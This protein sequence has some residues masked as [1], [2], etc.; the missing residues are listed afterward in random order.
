MIRIQSLFG[1][2]MPR[3]ITLFSVCLF[4]GFVEAQTPDKV[5]F[6][7]DIRPLFQEKCIGC[8]G[9]A[10][11]MGGMRLDRRSS[12]MGI[13]SGTTIGPGNADGSRL[14]LKLI[15]T[16]FGGRMPPTGP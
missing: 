16:K 8:H 6:R 14:Y 4:A 3:S 2:S 5:D 13:R 1:R 7:R 15:S 9:P 10:Q 11:Q 12:A